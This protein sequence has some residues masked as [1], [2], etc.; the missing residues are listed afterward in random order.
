VIQELSA[1]L[2][3]S[4]HLALLS[5]VKVSPPKVRVHSNGHGPLHD[6]TNYR[7]SAVPQLMVHYHYTKTFLRDETVGCTVTVLST[8]LIV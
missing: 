5:F 7:Q 6:D 2:S 1:T 4:L 8:V 3:R